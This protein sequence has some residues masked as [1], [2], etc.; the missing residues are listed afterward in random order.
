MEYLSQ[1][2]KIWWLQMFRERM[3][4]QFRMFKHKHDTGQN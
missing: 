1:M 3:F 4:K 2:E